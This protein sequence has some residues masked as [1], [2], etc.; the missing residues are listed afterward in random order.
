MKQSLWKLALL[1]SSTMLINTTIWIWHFLLDIFIKF[2]QLSNRV[3]ILI[4]Q[5]NSLDLQN[6]DFSTIGTTRE[7]GSMLFWSRTRTS[8]IYGC[9]ISHPSISFLLSHSGFIIGRLIL[10]WL[11]RFSQNPSWMALSYSK[12]L[13]LFP[14]NFQFFPLYYSFSVNLT[15]LG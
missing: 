15:L 13:L 1:K 8:I 7:H 12:V 6:Q 10:V 3:G 14:K 11:L 2:L 9:S 4:F 5:E